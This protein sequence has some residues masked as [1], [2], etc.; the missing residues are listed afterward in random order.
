[1]SPIHVLDA[2][3]GGS[4]SLVSMASAYPDMQFCGADINPTALQ[5]QREL[6]S[7]AG[8]GNVSLGEVDLM[9]LRGLPVPSSGFDVILSSG[10]LHHLSDPGS[11]LSALRQ[12]LAPHGVLVLMVYGRYGRFGIERLAEAIERVHGRDGDVA[13]RLRFGRA[14]VAAMNELDSALLHPHREDPR[15]ISEGEFVD[16]YLNPQERYYEVRELFALLSRAGLRFL[17]W[18]EPQEWSMPALFRDPAVV[19]ELESLEPIVRYEVVERLFD[20]P[21]LTLVAC[22]AEA[23]A[24]PPLD[25]PALER[26]RVAWNPQCAVSTTRRSVGERELIEE[27][28]VRI[29]VQ[30]PL[31]LSP[32][33]AAVVTAC[34]QEDVAGAVIAR[35]QALTEPDPEPLWE[36]LAALLDLEVLYVTK[37]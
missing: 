9:T 37:R 34:A 27:V 12:V 23:S 35:A 11:G 17:R 5:M 36:T 15:S 28:A 4:D 33:A 13:E 25:R 8:V 30:P 6:I 3:C 32:D 10:V 16:R 24:A 18:L 1:V 2:G 31:V 22:Q 21:A 26:A 19:N 14:L 20:R 29:R 7:G